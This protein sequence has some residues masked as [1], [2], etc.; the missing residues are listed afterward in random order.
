MTLIL[1]SLIFY[2]H[3]KIYWNCEIAN[4]G[5]EVGEFLSKKIQLGFYHINNSVVFFLIRIFATRS[6][7]F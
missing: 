3:K 1:F 4:A 6:T 2:V 7:A 5:S